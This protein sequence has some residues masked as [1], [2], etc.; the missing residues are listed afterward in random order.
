MA[1]DWPKAQGQVESPK[2]S[3]GEKLITGKPGDLLFL[4]WSPKEVDGPTQTGPDLLTKHVLCFADVLM[5]LICPTYISDLAKTWHHRAALPAWAHRLSIPFCWPHG[6]QPSFHEAPV[7]HPDP[8]PHPPG[9]PWRKA[10]SHGC[11]GGWLMSFMDAAIGYS[12]DT[13]NWVGC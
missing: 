12:V 9:F 7:A 5:N 8:T 11:L 2:F 13:V 6:P 10:W 4:I 3:T 1:K